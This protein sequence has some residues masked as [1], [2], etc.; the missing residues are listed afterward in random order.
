MDK[1]ACRNINH[2]Q[3]PV[4]TS[5]IQASWEAETGRIRFEAGQAN[6]S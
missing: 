4:V 5:V 6:N 2:S 1:N 3:V